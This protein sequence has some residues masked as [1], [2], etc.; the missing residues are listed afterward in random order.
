MKR[1][2]DWEK[3]WDYMRFGEKGN[4]VF[5]DENGRKIIRET[6]YTDTLWF[7][8]TCWD[9]TWFKGVLDGRDAIDWLFE[10]I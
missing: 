6:S 3:V 4:S 9:N 5:N 10:V 1:N 8:C 2:K 7:K